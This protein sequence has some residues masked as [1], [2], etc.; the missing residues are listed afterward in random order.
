VTVP[1]DRIDLPGEDV[2]QDRREL[3]LEIEDTDGG[4]VGECAHEFRVDSGQNMVKDEFRE[5]PGR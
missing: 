5:E 4:I 3:R 2:F 1:G